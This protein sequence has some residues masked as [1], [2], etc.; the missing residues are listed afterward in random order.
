MRERRYSELLPV[1]GDM[2]TS[3]RHREVDT[4]YKI[5]GEEY[6][7]LQGRPAQPGNLSYH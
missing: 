6:S 5:D 7:Y 3:T 1:F 2:H 4:I